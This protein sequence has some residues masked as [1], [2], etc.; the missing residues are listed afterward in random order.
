MMMKTRV[1]AMA[2]L[3]P[4]ALGTAGGA[5]SKP[6]PWIH[7]HVEEARNE[8]KVNVNL[9]FSLVEA[10][11]AMAPEKLGHEGRIRLD[12]HGCDL[13]L[14]DARRL[15][16]E[17]RESGQ[18][19]IV[20]VEEKGETVRVFRE[21]DQVRV[22]VDKPQEKEAV[23]IRIPVSVV[24]ALLSGEGRDLNVRG[25]LAELQKLRGDVVRVDEKDSKVRIWIDERS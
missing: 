22:S 15:W 5:Q 25:A 6:T 4:M 23:E 7:V 19:E 8:S 10:A 24:D 20:S 14:Q 17:L 9:P 16:K 13:S 21:G 3:V 18:A 2:T 11:L 12:D 1:F